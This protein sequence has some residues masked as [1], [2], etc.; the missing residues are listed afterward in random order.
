MVVYSNPTTATPVAF[1]AL[2]A[3]GTLNSFNAILGWPA[4]GIAEGVTEG[5][6]IGKHI[7]VHFFILEFYLKCGAIQNYA[8]AIPTDQYA[9]VMCHELLPT[10]GQVGTQN[11]QFIA[12]VGNYFVPGGVWNFN[13]A[14]TNAF[15]PKTEWFD[16]LTA[17]FFCKK[18]KILKLEQWTSAV[19]GAVDAPIRWGPPNGGQARCKFSYR[20]KL[21][22][23]DTDGHLIPDTPLPIFAFQNYYPFNVTILYRY[24]MVFSIV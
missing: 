13:A 3:F 1:D 11:A 24:K 20:N 19:E 2:T 23:F 22:K 18:G 12:N 15:T 17:G 6:R 7:Y 9:H 16:P 8:N 21:C 5:S 14:Q 10:K 4:N